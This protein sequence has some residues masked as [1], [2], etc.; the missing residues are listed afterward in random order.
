LTTI[1]AVAADGDGNATTATCAHLDE[2]EDVTP[3][4]TGMCADCVREGSQW[5]HLRE[6]LGCGHVACCDNSPR[7]HATAHWQHTHHPVIKSVEP[8][9]NWAWCYA[10]GLF[11]LPAA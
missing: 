6:C 2:I 1:W 10:D 3:D 5:V 9:E 4:S 11:L 7:R 8:G